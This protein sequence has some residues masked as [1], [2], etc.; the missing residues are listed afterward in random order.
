MV[1]MVSQMCWVKAG[2]KDV[3]RRASTCRKAARTRGQRWAGVSSQ[4]RASSC[5]TTGCSASADSLC[6]DTALA[7]CSQKAEFG[8]VTPAGETA[9]QHSPPS[10]RG[11]GQQ[12]LQLQQV[13][14]DS[15]VRE[16]LFRCCRE[17]LGQLQEEPAALGRGDNRHQ[18]PGSHCSYGVNGALCQPQQWLQEGTRGTVEQK[19]HHVVMLWL[20]ENLTRGR[21]SLSTMAALPTTG[22]LG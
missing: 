10:A 2:L 20:E 11:G 14:M 18:S 4:P 8:T 19:G 13:P 15:V 3:G 16:D 12:C 17:L 22:A 5:R 21:A 7:Q 1:L 9:G 6:G